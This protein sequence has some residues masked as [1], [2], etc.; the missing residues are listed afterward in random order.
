MTCRPSEKRQAMGLSYLPDRSA[1]SKEALIV[2][3]II[4]DQFGS[5]NVNRDS[6][7]IAETYCLPF[8]E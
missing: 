8:T 3:F 7:A 6:P 5:A 4:P 1:S 2:R